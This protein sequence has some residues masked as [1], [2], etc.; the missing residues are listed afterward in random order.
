MVEK[1][2]KV[3]GMGCE[4]CVKR[5]TKAAMSVEGVERAD[6]DL[7][8]EKLNVEYDENKAGFG[9]LKEAVED[10]GYGLEEM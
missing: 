6:V 5:V 2:Y 7:A 1:N 10:A 3:T 4:A 8:A 9:R